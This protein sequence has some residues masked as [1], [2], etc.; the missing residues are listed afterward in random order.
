V[1][2]GT[3]ARRGRPRGWAIG[4]WVSLGVKGDST[5]WLS[6]LMSRI[7]R[8]DRSQLLLRGVA[9]QSTRRRSSEAVGWD[10]Q[11]GVVQTRGGDSTQ[12][13]PLDDKRGDKERVRTARAR[14]LCAVRS[15]TRLDEGCSGAREAFQV[16]YSKGQRV[17]GA[18]NEELRAA[19]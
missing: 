5:V 8:I 16:S 1:N 15:V 3:L 13:I 12:L 10:S 9:T 2:R 14:Q 17:E 7:V 19:S 11:P 4:G 18:L 6:M